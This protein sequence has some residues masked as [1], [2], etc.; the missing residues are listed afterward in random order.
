MP[1]R[2]QTSF[3]LKTGRFVRAIK[4]AEIISATF[5]YFLLTPTTPSETTSLQRM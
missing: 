3:A 5:I 4:V 2:Q 1:L